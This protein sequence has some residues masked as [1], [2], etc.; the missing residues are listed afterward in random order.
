MNWETISQIA[1]S[2]SSI[3]G[4]ASLVAGYQLYY[5]SKKDEYLKNYRAILSR[6]NANC[7]KLN[8]LVSYEL[9]HEMSYSVICQDEV[10]AMLTNL[11]NKI[12]EKGI[13]DIGKD[14]DKLKKFIKSNIPNITMPVRSSIVNDYESTIDLCYFDI[15]RY[16]IDYPGLYRIIDAILK[17][18]RNINFSNRKLVASEE[19]WS[20]LLA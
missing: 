15:S 2:L 12:K 14:D 19:I 9:F 11:R 8:R 4:A 5:S 20:I 17:I 18:F 16:N 7:Q 1:T 3:T 13:E 6:L 10:E